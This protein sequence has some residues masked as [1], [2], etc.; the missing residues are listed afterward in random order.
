VLLGGRRLIDRA[1]EAASAARQVVVVGPADV[2]PPGVIVTLEDPPDGGP[3]AGI[4]AGLAALTPGSDLVLILACDVPRAAGARAALL[5]AVDSDRPG[6][7]SADGAVLVD[8]DGRVQPLV[9]LYR[10]RSLDA[11][12]AA[13]AAGGGV[14][15][16]SVHRLLRPLRL[17]RVP[18][19]GGNALDVDT[20]EDL[21]RAERSV[22]DA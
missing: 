22:R 2:A 10:R 18:D 19:P 3:V 11:A 6:A 14:R 7:G 8:A 4:A 21:A 5:A 9:G 17:V 15:D 1:L 12:L 13:L 20:W 16:A